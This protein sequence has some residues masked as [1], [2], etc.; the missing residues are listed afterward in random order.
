M[1]GDVGQGLI[2]AVLGAL[3]AS[4]KVKA[5]K[6]MAGLG[7]LIAVC[8]LSATVFGFLYGSIFGFEDILHPVWMS[9]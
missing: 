6:G 9:P 8:G 1:F 7:G 4:G 2:L 3:M 5:M